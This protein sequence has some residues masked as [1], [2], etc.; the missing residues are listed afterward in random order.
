MMRWRIGG[1]KGERGVKRTKKELVSVTLHKALIN[2]SRNTAHAI[3][4]RAA[5]FVVKEES[6]ALLR[7]PLIL[8]GKC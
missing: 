2:S 8:H 5:A 4:K 6:F 3:K 7:M 1:D